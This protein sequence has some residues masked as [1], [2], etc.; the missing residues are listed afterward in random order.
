MILPIDA[1]KAFDKAQH[2]LMIKTLNKVRLKRT[3]FNIIK[4]IYEKPTSNIILHG[5]KLRTFPLWSGTRQGCPLSSFLFNI[6]LQ[7]LASAIRQ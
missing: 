5:E 7:V 3:Y 4:V 6:V 1:E 2:S